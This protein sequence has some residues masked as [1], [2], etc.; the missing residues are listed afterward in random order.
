MVICALALPAAIA[1]MHVVRNQAAP[2]PIKSVGPVS[3]AAGQPANIIA[4]A[5]QMDKVATALRGE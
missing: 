4:K 5:S 1:A 3:K 2:A